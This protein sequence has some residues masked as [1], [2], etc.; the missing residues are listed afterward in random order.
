MKSPG[1]QTGP[2]LSQTI[3]SRMAEVESL[4]IQVREL[5]QKKGLSRA[6]FPVE[7][8]AREC[9][10]NAVLHGNRN[11]SDKSVL[12]RLWIGRERIRLQ[13][14]DEGPGFDWRKANIN[15]S[16]TTSTSGRGLP[17]YALYA[18]RVQ[19]N[20]RGNQITLWIGKSNRTG[21]DDGTMAAYV[22]D[23]NDQQCS[24]KMT[25]DLTAVLVAGLQAD[26][27]E[28]LSKG[29]REVD[30]DLASTVM[31]DSSGIGLLIAAANSLSPHGGKVMVTNV[32]ADIFRLLQ[33]MRLTARLNVSARVE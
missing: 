17:L 33:S 23:Q 9:L 2:S 20:R 27:K 7:L 19:F 12:F 13:V 29:V 32:S 6:C 21:K 10:N 1:K 25:G 14:T 3:P 15:R 22:I 24:V 18:E 30:F 31:L 4:C 8:L 5:L 28:K 26:L 16:G 11:D